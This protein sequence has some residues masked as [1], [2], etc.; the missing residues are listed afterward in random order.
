MEEEIILGCHCNVNSPD[1]YLGT[2][3]DALS[4][5][6]TT[7]MF[8][9][10]APQNTFRVPTER[11]KIEEGR[12]LIKEAGIKE[13]N[14]VA[15]APYII[16]PAN[17][18][19]QSTR[20]LARDFLLKELER[21]EAF[22]VSILVLHPGS[23]VGA[24]A[25]AGIKGA[26]EVLNE[27]LS[28]DK[29]H[30]RIAIETMAGK[31]GEIGTTFTQIKEILDGVNYPDRVGVCLDTCHINDAGYDVSKVDDVINEFDRVIGLDR[32]LVVHLNDSK[33]IM[34]AHKDRHENIGY[35][36]IGFDVLHEYLVHPKLKNIPKILETPY[37]NEKPP[38]KDEISMLRNGKMIPGWK[39]KYLA[40]E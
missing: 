34:G 36:E 14:I 27:V 2:V 13:E 6:C 19:N 11:F 3:R 28:V 4:Y 33:N 20:D 21:V 5:G 7:F 18:V 1:Y 25:E 30:V 38:Y 26:I 39:D 16:N 17:T 12:A 23:H 24:G 32:L 31:G 37:V 8:Y 9:T 22:H 35:G 10:G 40:T 15:H 29:T